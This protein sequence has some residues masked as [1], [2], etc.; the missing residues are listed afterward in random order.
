MLTTSMEADGSPGGFS[1]CVLGRLLVIK[2]EARAIL[3][4]D[5]ELDLRRLE[6]R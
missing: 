5:S 3:A 4:G 1:Y 2:V 6:V